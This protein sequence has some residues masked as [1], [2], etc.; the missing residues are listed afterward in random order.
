MINE[1]I[2]KQKLSV[3]LSPAVK[4]R[5]SE[6]WESEGYASVSDYVNAIFIEYFARKD[7]KK[8]LGER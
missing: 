6:E 4:K 2:K 3:T 7:L 1:S 8:E 5:I